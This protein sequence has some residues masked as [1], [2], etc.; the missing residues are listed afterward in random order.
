M[1][2]RPP[3]GREPEGP[4]GRPGGRAIA[5]SIVLHAVAVAGVVASGLASPPAVPEF[6]VYRVDIVSPP[7]AVAGDPAP[8]V[9]AEEEPEPEPEQP[10]PEPEPEP[11][12]QPPPPEPE[13]EREPEPEPEETP[14]VEETPPEPEPDEPEPEPE[15]AQPREA[16]GAEPERDAERSGE[17]L[18]VQIS[19]RDFPFPGYLDNII[20]QI[21]RYFRWSGAPGLV[22]EVYFVIRRDGSVEDIRLLRGSGNVQFDFQAMAAVEQAANR[23]AF[24]SLPEEFERDRLPVSFY[25]RPAQ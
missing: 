15:P 2:E 16:R 11:E 25:F 22:A 6:E 8:A 13:P 7:P 14:P 5:G 1:T 3:S 19:G 9:Q 4:A 24:G 10:E 21:H 23:G 12:S 17:G 18:N 20:R